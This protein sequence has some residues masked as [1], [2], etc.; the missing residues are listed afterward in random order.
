MVVMPTD[1]NSALAPTLRRGSQTKFGRIATRTRLTS[2][3]LGVT[4]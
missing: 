1:L 3:A 4:R 2:Q